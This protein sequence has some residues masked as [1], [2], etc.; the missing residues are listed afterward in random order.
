MEILLVRC[1]LFAKF[2]VAR[3]EL[4]FHCVVLFLDIVSV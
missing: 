3:R 2:Y 4:T 1:S